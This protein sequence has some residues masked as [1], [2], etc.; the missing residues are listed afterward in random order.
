M[1]KNVY[2][3][4]WSRG[5]RVRTSLSK[6]NLVVQAFRAKDEKDAGKGAA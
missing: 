5:I 1:R 6:G 4:A 3:A 2:E